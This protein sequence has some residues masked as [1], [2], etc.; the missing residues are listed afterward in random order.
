MTAV[1]EPDTI[2]DW[3]TDKMVPGC[4]VTAAGLTTRSLQAEARGFFDRLQGAGW[5]RTPFP[6]DAPNEA[7]LRFRKSGVDC[8]FS[9]YSGGLLGTDAELEVD[10]MVVPGPGEQRYNFLVLCM[11]A[12]DVAPSR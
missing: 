3:R 11:P 6:D 1:V 10:D 5:E 12:V 4:R 2:D 9:F 7:S 8:L